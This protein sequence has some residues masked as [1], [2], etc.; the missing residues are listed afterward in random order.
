M[1]ELERYAETDEISENSQRFAPIPCPLPDLRP[2]HQFV[3]NT[4]RLPTPRTNLID[5]FIAL[6]VDRLI[7]EARDLQARMLGADFSTRDFALVTALMQRVE[8]A[9]VLQGA[10]W[11]DL[12]TTTNVERRA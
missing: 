1:T 9:P 11:L 3:Q 5:A 7:D 10:I 12:P 8:R 4:V 6:P 2:P